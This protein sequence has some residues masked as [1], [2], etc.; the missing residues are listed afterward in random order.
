[1]YQWFRLVIE[2]IDCPVVIVTHDIIEAIK[3]S[4]KIA[5]LSGNPATINTIYDNCGR[6]NAD[7]EIYQSEHCLGLIDNI[8]KDL[9]IT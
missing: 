9:S 6:F 2:K 3:L 8:E 1:M 7:K 5:V 4:D